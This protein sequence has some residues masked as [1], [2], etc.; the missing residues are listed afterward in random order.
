MSDAVFPE[1]RRDC[2][3]RPFAA[4]GVPISNRAD[5]SSGAVYLIQLSPTAGPRDIRG[6]VGIALRGGNVT[7]AAGIAARIVDDVTGDVVEGTTR[8]RRLL[9]QHRGKGSD[10]NVHACEHEP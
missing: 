10:C 9:P 6:V 2:E 4:V 5:L 8:H 3:R 7:I 1:V